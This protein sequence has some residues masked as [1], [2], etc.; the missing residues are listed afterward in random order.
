M[1]YYNKHLHSIKNNS[2]LFTKPNVKTFVD[3]LGKERTILIYS[4]LDRWVQHYL[5]LIIDP[6]IISYVNSYV[7]G[8]VRGRDN[9]QASEYILKNNPNFVLK[10]DIKSYFNSIDLET[11]LK[12]LDLV[13]I[14]NEIKIMTKNSLKH[15]PT[16]GLPM[17]HV[18]SPTLSNL[19]LHKL[20]CYFPHNYARY[21]DD[22]L[23][24][25]NNRFES[26]KV[27][28]STKRILGDLNLRLNFSKTKLFL[29]PS[30]K[31]LL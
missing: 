7:F 15:N 23:F 22:L 17:G 4:V 10:L 9:I 13:D 14:P 1:H 21:S 18:L 29:N 28:L 8:Y 19:Y 2:Y 20:D 26:L 27:I 11:T 16:Q 24:A 6:L 25:I 30:I 5:K 3:Y 31:E 12:N